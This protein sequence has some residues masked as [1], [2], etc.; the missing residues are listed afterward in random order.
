M[1][2]VTLTVRSRSATVFKTGL[3]EAAGRAGRMHIGRPKSQCYAS[4]VERITSRQNSIVA[5]YRGATRGDE[6][7]MLLLDG[8]HLVSD[9]LAARIALQHLMVAAEAQ[10]S[11]E[12]RPLLDRAAAQQIYV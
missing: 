10:D 2:L 1:D 7:G 12:I 9:A 4:A 6:V 8:A 3:F 11:P 5:R